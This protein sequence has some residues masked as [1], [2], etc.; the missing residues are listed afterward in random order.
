MP[1]KKY[2]DQEQVLTHFIR[3][4]LT[5]KAFDRLDKISKESDCHTVGEVARKLLST[6]KITLFYRDVTLDRFMEELAL[7]RK[8]LKAIGININQLTKGYHI[9]SKKQQP[10]N[11]IMAEV[12]KLYRQV[13]GKTEDLLHIINQLAQKWL[14]E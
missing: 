10:T 7:V 2:K 12:V 1:R 14:Q 5:K 4:R 8:E 3:T 6:E 11:Y 9:A 13:D